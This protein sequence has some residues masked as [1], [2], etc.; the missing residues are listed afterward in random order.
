MESLA[1]PIGRPPHPAVT[2]NLALALVASSN[3]PLLLLDGNLQVVVASPSFCDAFG[4]DPASVEG[5]RFDQLGAGEWNLPTLLALLKAATHGYPK[6]ED[7]EMDYV[8]EARPTRRLA[9][10]AQKL[11]YAEEGD[12]RLLL[13]LSD[14]TAVRS[15]EKR[16]SDMQEENAALRRELQQRTPNS[17]QILASLI[18]QSARKIPSGKSR[19]EL[20]DAHHRIMSA[21]ALHHQLAVPALGDV[22]LC[23]YFAALCENIANSLIPDRDRLSLTVTADQCL[24]SAETSVS[25]GLIVTELAINALRHAFPHGR[26]GAIAVDYRMRGP[27]WMLSVR[28]N[29]AGLPPG[30]A[31]PGLGTSI[32]Q[33]LA[34]QLEAR[35]EISEADPGTK[36]AIVHV[37]G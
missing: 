35:V 36:V 18:R 7:Y 19:N 3:A 1:R 24:A 22:E 11:E 14:I 5:R 37:P 17:L 8:R 6:L 31:K 26:A 15:A 10:N 13:T 9:L 2:F 30:G 12:T 34:E 25:L 20:Y 4:M 29:G 33:A 27:D 32:V 16:N 28:D 23:P 21:A